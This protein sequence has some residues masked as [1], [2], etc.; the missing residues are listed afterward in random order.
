MVYT[1]FANG[2]SYHEAVDSLLGIFG[3]EHFQQYEVYPGKSSIKSDLISLELGCY[4]F[5]EQKAITLG[6]L[7]SLVAPSLEA[8][9][10][11]LTL[12]SSLIKLLVPE[13]YW[14]N[15][16]F[17]NEVYDDEDMDK[18]SAFIYFKN[19]ERSSL[20]DFSFT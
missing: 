17:N 16:G 3:C 8:I 9:K 11:G 2:L 19:C 5:V 14:R 13:K 20:N 18:F 12:Q 4:N 15:L 6:D 1:R 7:S 10:Q